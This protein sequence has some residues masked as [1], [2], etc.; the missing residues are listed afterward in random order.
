MTDNIPDAVK[1]LTDNRVIYE[2]ENVQARANDDLSLLL[3]AYDELLN[4]IR[5]IAPFL[6]IHGVYGYSITTTDIEEA[7]K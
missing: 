6:A 3:G 5:D 4:H 1:R 2:D 7:T